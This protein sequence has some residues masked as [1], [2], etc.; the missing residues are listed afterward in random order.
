MMTIHGSAP[1]G[2]LQVVAETLDGAI[3]LDMAFR[4]HQERWAELLDSAL[5]RIDQ[6]EPVGDGIL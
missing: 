3:P 5:G 2:M 6:R 1:M 4:S